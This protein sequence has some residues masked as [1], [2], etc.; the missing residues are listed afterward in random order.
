MG[1]AAALSTPGLFDYASVA[2]AIYHALGAWRRLALET[3]Y[4]PVVR[5]TP[6]PAE[7]WALR[8]TGD[9][10]VGVTA[11]GAHVYVKGCV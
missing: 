6:V 10:L 4:V 1:A 11:H 5:D 9:A 2:R 8:W 7:V 3:G